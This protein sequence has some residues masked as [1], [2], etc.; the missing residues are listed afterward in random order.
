M[1][2]DTCNIGV[3]NAFIST[4]DGKY[5]FRLTGVDFNMKVEVQRLVD[6]G[7]L[8]LGAPVE[9]SRLVSKPTFYASLEGSCECVELLTEDDGGESS[10]TNHLKSQL[11]AAKQE[12]TAKSKEVESLRNK[13]DARDEDVSSLLKRIKMKLDMPA[14]N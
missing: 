12:L 14:Q 9:I 10:R 6:C 2:P 4:A 13:L 8:P 3:C 7:S 11:N 1:K 5:K